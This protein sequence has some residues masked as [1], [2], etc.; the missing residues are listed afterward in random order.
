MVSKIRVRIENYPKHRGES[1]III[2]IIIIFPLSLL[3]RVHS[4]LN[5]NIK[6][7]KFKIKVKKKYQEGRSN[8]QHSS[9]NEIWEYILT[10]HNDEKKKKINFC[11]LSYVSLDFH[12]FLLLNNLRGVW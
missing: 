6:K 5:N 8:I 4:K 9:Q 7:L 11:Q 2:I 12:C 1:I 3:F 10:K